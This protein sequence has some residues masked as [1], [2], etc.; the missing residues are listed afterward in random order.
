MEEA[1][2]S[3]ALAYAKFLNLENFMDLGVNAT[4][5]CVKHMMTKFVQLMEN[6]TVESVCVKK[7]GLGV[8]VSSQRCVTLQSRRARTCVGILKV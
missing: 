3:V 5:G 7:A 2:A 8:F 6:A 1:N 4:T